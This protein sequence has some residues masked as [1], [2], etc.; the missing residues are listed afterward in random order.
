M[1]RLVYDELVASEERLVQDL[2]SLINVYL[3]PLRRRPRGCGRGAVQSLRDAPELLRRAQ[4]QLQSKA[5]S[6]PKAPLPDGG[7]DADQEPD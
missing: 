6:E 4:C 2:G 3:L 1:R 7:G 5:V